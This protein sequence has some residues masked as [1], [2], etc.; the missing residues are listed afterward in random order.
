VN[1]LPFG[2]VHSLPSAA[3]A[4]SIL[5]ASRTGLSLFCEPL[6]R[7]RGII[8]YSL[9]LWFAFT[10]RDEISSPDPK[11]LKH[12]LPRTGCSIML[13]LDLIIVAIDFVS[14]A[15]SSCWPGFRL[16]PAHSAA[17]LLAFYCGSFDLR[18]A[19]PRR[20]GKDGAFSYIDL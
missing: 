9:H 4:A 15:G 3:S 18:D 2:A 1:V 13:D 20:T 6:G 16:Q 19:P 17:L 7:P 14:N 8:F 12:A 10:S 5:K 11:S